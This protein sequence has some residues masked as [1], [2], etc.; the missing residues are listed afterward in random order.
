MFQGNK[1]DIRLSPD[2]QTIINRAL[3]AVAAVSCGC[4]FVVVSWKG[5]EGLLTQ[6]KTVPE[7]QPVQKEEEYN[8]VMC[9]TNSYMQIES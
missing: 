9:S 5:G 6:N 3:Q 7:I 4:K 8:W 2:N 1:C